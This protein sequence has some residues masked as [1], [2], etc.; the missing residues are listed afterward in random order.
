MKKSLCII[1][2]IAALLIVFSVNFASAKTVDGMIIKKQ[3]QKTGQHPATK[4]KAMAKKPAV[5]TAPK[6]LQKAAPTPAPR[7]KFKYIQVQA[8]L[9]WYY[10]IWTLFLGGSGLFLLGGIIGRVLSF[11]PIPRR[12]EENVLHAEDAEEPVKEDWLK[13]FFGRFW[14]PRVSCQP[15][16]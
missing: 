10:N 8:P 13:K 9:P 7:M 5:E 4:K 1:G 2:G 3:W 6:Q 11:G 16:V 14:K 15:A 12:L